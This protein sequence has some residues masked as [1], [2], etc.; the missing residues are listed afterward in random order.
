MSQRPSYG[1]TCVEKTR[2]IIRSNKEGVKPWLVRNVTNNDNQ[3][4]Q[5]HN[6]NNIELGKDRYP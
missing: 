1:R 6:N 2:H 4:D 5:S 3:D